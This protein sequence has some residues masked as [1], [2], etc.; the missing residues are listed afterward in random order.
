ME[1]L[2]I[3]HSSCST[4]GQAMRQNML[5]N[6]NR[7]QVQRFCRHQLWGKSWSV[8]FGRDK[9]LIDLDPTPR[10]DFR[11][12]L[13][14]GSERRGAAESFTVS[15]YITCASCWIRVWIPSFSSPLPRHAPFNMLGRTQ[16]SLLRTATRNAS[17]SSTAP[18]SSLA[19]SKRARST[20][21]SGN[22]ISP[23]AKARV[24]EHSRNIQSS[25]KTPAQLAL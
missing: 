12:R 18:V 19:L 25:A 6:S 11:E 2:P 23:E 17:S 9:V 5:K 15:T 7:W 1:N 14:R 22:A 10:S 20:D 13:N 4:H 16:R 8:T 24:R 21:I 3:G